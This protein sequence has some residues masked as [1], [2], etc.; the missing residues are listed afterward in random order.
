MIL[1]ANDIGVLRVCHIRSGPGKVTVLPWPRFI[2]AVS[3][4]TTRYEHY[5][6]YYGILQWVTVSYGTFACIFT[7]CKILCMALGKLSLQLS[8]AS[9][10]LERG[11]V[12]LVS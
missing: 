6:P 3:G 5:R 8:V 11:S 9:S 10:V 1:S 12:V 7:V 2:M 4:S